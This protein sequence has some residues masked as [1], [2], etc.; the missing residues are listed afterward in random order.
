MPQ[1]FDLLPWR[2]REPAR[3]MYQRL[4]YLTGVYIGRRDPLIPPA[5]LHDIGGTEH[6]A[7]GEEFLLHF[8]NLAKLKPDEHVLDVGSGTGRMARPLTRYLKGGTYDGI[9]IVDESVRWCRKVYARY[10]NFQFHYSDIYNSLYNGNGRYQASEYRFPFESSSFDFAF[11]GSVFTHMLAKDMENYLAELTR[12]LKKGGRCLITYFLLY[13]ESLQRINDKVSPLTFA[14]EVGGSRVEMKATPEYCVA[15]EETRIRQL[16]EKFG[17]AVQEPVY[18]G[19]WCG[20]K[21]WLSYQDLVV[22]TKV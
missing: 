10:P 20:R 8:I 18:C 21:D 12:V 13:P 15:Y 9:D 3:K 5:Y 14:H 1:I 7:V 2:L 16:Y 4:E 11:L 17:F 6:V 19:S 22:A